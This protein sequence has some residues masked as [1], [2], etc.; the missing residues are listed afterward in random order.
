MSI[1][2]IENTNKINWTNAII[3]GI[4]GTIAFDILGFLFSGTWFSTAKLIANKTELGIVYGMFG[5]YGNG[6]LL[7]ILYAGIAP[8][9][10]GPNFFRAQLFSIAETVVLVW[11]FI[12]PLAGAGIAGLDISV[13]VP[14]ESFVKH[15]AYGI[16]LWYFIHNFI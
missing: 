5:H 8:S 6:I 7:A 10:F 1:Q 2:K 13:M 15:F 11:L 14:I 4:I 16:A 9:L 12:F 3:A